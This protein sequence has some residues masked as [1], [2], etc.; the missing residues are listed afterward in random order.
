M[1]SE[2]RSPSGILL[3]RFVNDLDRYL[4]EEAKR[5]PRRSLPQTWQR[6]LQQLRVRMSGLVQGGA[7]ALTSLAVILAI[8]I[9]PGTYETAPS[10]PEG[11]LAQP[12]SSSTLRLKAIDAKYVDSSYEMMGGLA[13]GERH[14]IGV[15]GII[16]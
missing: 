4:R 6:A 9:A 7:M 10:A 2:M 13:I 16:E 15:N 12:S 11:V 14:D 8:G 1:P 3:D 5:T